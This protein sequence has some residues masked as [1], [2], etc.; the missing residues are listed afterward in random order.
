LATCCFIMYC[1][2]KNTSKAGKT[3]KQRMK[4]TSVPAGKM[5]IG[6]MKLNEII[7]QRYKAFV[8]KYTQNHRRCC[9][10][11]IMEN[12]TSPAATAPVAFT[13]SAMAELHRLQSSLA[14]SE[15]SYLRIGVKGGGCSGMSYLLA[16]DKKEEGDNEYEVEGIRMVMN[17]AHVMYVL[18]MHVDWENGLDNRGFSFNN[19][20]A[21]STCG[22]GQS[23]SA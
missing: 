17:K 8:E 11:V 19:P 21:T 10:F 20:N 22:C 7:Q 12:V 9:I 14:L 5:A 6:V 15:E 3:I 4:I 23:F 2:V 13:E 1:A 16:F 18:G